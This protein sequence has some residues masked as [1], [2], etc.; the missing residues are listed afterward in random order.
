ME[1]SALRI[2]ESVPCSRNLYVSWPNNLKVGN[3][4]GICNSRV[5]SL[6]TKSV[7]DRWRIL[8]WCLIELSHK[9]AWLVPEVMPPVCRNHC[10][11]PT[12]EDS[13]ALEEELLW[14]NCV[15]VT[16]HNTKCKR[17]C[18]NR[19][20]GKSPKRWWQGSRHLWMPPST[21]LLVTLK[22]GLLVRCVGKLFV[23]FLKMKENVGSRD[24]GAQWKPTWLWHCTGMNGSLQPHLLLELLVENLLV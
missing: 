2:L 1:Y 14:R 3:R 24:D 21:I 16:V 9:L 15:V 17:V 11:Y 22:Y 23:S 5:A 20:R 6:V 12:R 4:N 10:R 19:S 7:E 13:F 18:F 8:L